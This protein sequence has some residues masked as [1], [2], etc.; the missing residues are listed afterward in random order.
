MGV[1]FA[2]DDVAPAADRLP[3]RQLA[4]LMG[5]VLTL[6]DD[7]ARPVVD[8]RGLHPLVAAV[9]RAFCDHRPLV[10]GPDAIWTTITQ[11]VAQHVRLN[12]E[13]LRPRLVRHAG[14]KRLTVERPDVHVLPTDPAAWAAI[15]GAWSAQLEDELG[16]GLVRLFT[17]PL[18]TTSPVDRVAAQIVLM[19]AVAPYY[20][21]Y[22]QGSIC[23]IPAITLR[24]AVDDWRALRARIDVIAELGLARWARSLGPILD[25]FVAAA[26][27]HADLPFWRRI[28][29]PRDAYGGDVITGWVARLFPY[30][31]ELGRDDAPNPLLD[32][33]LDQPRDTTEGGVS[34][35]KLP[36]AP[37]R[38]AFH[39]RV[40]D[41]HRDLTL[42][43][44]VTAVIQ[45]ADLAL[46][47]ICGWALRPHT[48][49]IHDVAHRLEAVAATTA[50]LRSTG[51]GDL[52]FFRSIP[53]GPAEVVALYR[54]IASATIA[55]R[56]GVCRLLPTA[57]HVRLE[58]EP[59]RDG[60][61][62][63]H[64]FLDLPDGT[65]IAGTVTR[66]GFGYARV[67][68]ANARVP[69]STFRRRHGTVTI[70]GIVALGP[71]LAAILTTL[72]DHGPS[73]LV[74]VGALADDIT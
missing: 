25:Q 67:P 39:V 28:Y 19:D 41:E 62:P 36:A 23:G 48:A 68:V 44:G 12:A 51:P 40:R 3:E 7:P 57:E 69:A 10:L 37:S 52:A 66:A 27:G 26:A 72:L 46:E 4:D 54:R 47:P 2:V 6:G 71:S 17:A 38:V 45:H 42:E 29:R 14:V 21:F 55:T 35:T 31:R 15:V 20:Y 60:V 24:G 32:L 53:E 30:L 5:E 63:L 61:G 64:R 18:S 22:F 33:P 1:T 56:Q 50:A 74:A 13:A 16:P 65:F 11:G 43:G 70:D 59:R 58:L 34:P 9:D 8:P 73:A 49:D